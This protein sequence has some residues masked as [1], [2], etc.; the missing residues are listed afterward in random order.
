MYEPSA[1]ELIEGPRLARG[2]GCDGRDGLLPQA[3]L[4]ALRPDR[5]QGPDRR[6]PAA[7]HD[8][9]A[10]DARRA[11]RRTREEIERAALGEGMRTLWDDGLAKVAAGLTSLEE[12]ARVIGLSRGGTLTGPREPSVDRS[13]GRIARLALSGG[14]PHF[15]VR[16]HR[17]VADALE[18]SVAGARAATAR[19]LGQDAVGGTSVRRRDGR[20]V[21][22][23][24][25]AASR[26]SERCLPRSKPRDPAFAE[27][28]NRVERVRAWPRRL[29]GGDVAAQVHQRPRLLP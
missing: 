23:D 18:P 17:L 25:G 1:D 21:P 9:G 7:R 13:G 8:G 15:G 16:A 29:L 24:E 26:P 11:R 3:R 4:P 2:G 19:A 20:R 12:L 28:L 5:L 27:R 14:M 6:L 22:P 10:R